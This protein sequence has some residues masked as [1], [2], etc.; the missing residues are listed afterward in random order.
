MMN[1]VI[2]TG[3]IMIGFTAA[4]LAAVNY[5]EKLLMKY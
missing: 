1:L 5:Y 3:V 2:L 4:A